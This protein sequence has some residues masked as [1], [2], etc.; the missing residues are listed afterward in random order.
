MTSA[1]WR[2]R[3]FVIGQEYTMTQD[4]TAPRDAF[5]AVAP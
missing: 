3:P 4:E 2:V 5:R 1:D